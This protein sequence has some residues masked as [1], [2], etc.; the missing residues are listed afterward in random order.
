MLALRLVFLETE[1]VLFGL[2]SCELHSSR[3]NNSSRGLSCKHVPSFRAAFKTNLLNGA[4]S[5][6]TVTLPYLAQHGLMI[7]GRLSLAIVPNQTRP[8]SKRTSEKRCSCTALGCDSHEMEAWS[9]SG[10]CMAEGPRKCWLASASRLLR[11]EHE[12]K[13]TLWSICDDHNTQTLRY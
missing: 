8:G 10:P 7:P 2:S 11:G 9:L 12:W 4:P 6:T 1:L 13:A 3:Q 5:V